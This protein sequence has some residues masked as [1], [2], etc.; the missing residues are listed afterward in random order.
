MFFI[1]AVKLPTPAAFPVKFSFSVPSGFT[2]AV[3]A[4]LP[5]SA[6]SMMTAG[7]GSAGS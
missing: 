3:A 1:V 5:L 7:A 4:K 2:V 6:P